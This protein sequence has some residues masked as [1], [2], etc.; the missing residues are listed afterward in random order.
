[1]QGEHKLTLQFANASHESYGPEYAK[2]I[3]VKVK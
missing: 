2:T 1:M 3:D